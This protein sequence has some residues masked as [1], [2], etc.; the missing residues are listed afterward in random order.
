LSEQPI[1]GS[2][3]NKRR[4]RRQDLIDWRR[5][6][7]IE[8]ISKCKTQSEIAGK[9]SVGIGT[10]NRDIS[11]FQAQARENIAKFVEKIQVEHEKSIIGIDAILRQSWALTEQAKDTKE[12]LQALTLAKECYAL[13]EDLICNG[14]VIDEAL[15]FVENKTELSK[16]VKALD[17][18]PHS[19]SEAGRSGEVK[20]DNEYDIQRSEK[21][22][23]EGEVRKTT[24]KTF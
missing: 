6:I 17:N 5:S 2:R 22:D 21:K 20:G 19:I 11:W 9:L 16:P 10:V 18:D 13:K 15:K 8:E 23:R 3:T 1:R 14:P 7:V 12:K 24:N 4:K